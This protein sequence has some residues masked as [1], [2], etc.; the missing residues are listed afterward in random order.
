MCKKILRFYAKKMCLSRLRFKQYADMIRLSA[1][2]KLD[3][4]EHYR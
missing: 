1:Q 2:V 3:D 4:L